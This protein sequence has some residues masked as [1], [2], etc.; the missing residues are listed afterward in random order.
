VPGTTGGLP[1]QRGLS[2]TSNPMAERLR[3]MGRGEDKMLVHMTP[4]EVGGL[5]QLAMAHGGS[6]TINPQTGLP[7]AGFLSKLLPTILGI[8]GAAFGLPTWAIGLGVGAGQTALTG[9]LG[10]GLT[11][12]L[13]AFGGAGIGQAAG[14]GG[15][16]SNNALGLMGGNAASS[17]AAAGSNLFSAPSVS[18]AP[19]AIP[20]AASGASKGFLGKFADATSLGQKGMIGKALP[21]MAGSA[22]LGGVSDAMQ[23]KMPTYN[24]D[25][26]GKSTYEGPYVP[27]KRDVQFQPYEQMKQT[28]GAE[29]KYFT[30]SN[31][32]PG[33]RPVSSLDEE[34]RAEYGFADGGI[35]QL[36]TP[37]GFN[38]LV[39][40]FNSANP[41]AVTA[42]M[43]PSSAAPASP[44]APAVGVPGTS[45][46][47]SP[48]VSPQPNTGGPGTGMIGMPELSSVDIANI[49]AQIGYAPKDGSPATTPIPERDIAYA[50][51]TDLYR[52]ITD[53]P[54]PYI[55]SNPMMPGRDMDGL[56]YTT[57][58][59][60]IQ[61][62]N[63]LYDRL[64][65]N[66][67]TSRDVDYNFAD[68]GAAQVPTPQGF[69]ELTSFFNAVNP[70]AIT[71]SMRPTSAPLPTPAAPAVGAPREQTYNFAN[72][73]S[74]TPMPGA[75]SFKDI[76]YVDIPGVGNVMI[77]GYSNYNF[78]NIDQNE[79]ARRYGFI[80]KAEQLVIREP[81]MTGIYDRFNMVENQLRN[82][83]APQAPDLTGIY[84]RFGQIEDRIRGI[85]QYQ[86]P[87]LSGIYDRFGQIESRISGMP[88]YQEPDLTGIYDRFGSIENQLRNIPTT[89]LTGIY[90][91]FGSI[92]NRLQGIPQYQEP[93]LSGIYDRFGQ[94]EN[95]LQNI[96]PTDLT[97]VYD[98]FG[99][100]ENRISGIPRYQEPD[101]SGVYDRFGQIES[102]LQNITPTDLTGVYDRFG[103]IETRLQNIT[104]TDLTGVYDRFGQIEN[105]LGSMTPTD[106]TGVYD[107]FN[108]L[109]GRFNSLPTPT[110]TDLTGVYDRFNQLEGRFNSLPAPTATD[111]SGIYDRFGQLESRISSLPAPTATDLSGV[112]DRFN[113]LEGRFNNL[114]AP[115]ATDLTGVYDRFNQLEGRISSMPA[116][117]ATD[118]TGV[119][120]RFNQL[121]GRVN[122]IPATD[123]TGVYDR[124]GQIESR[125]GSM[126]PTDL[127]GVYDQLAEL[128]Q[129]YSNQ[130]SS[131]NVT[132]PSISGGSTPTSVDTGGFYARGGEVGMSDGAFVVDARTVSELGNGSSN[133]GMDFLSRLGGRPLRG[134][135]DGV[136]DSIPARIG[137]RQEARVARDEVIFQ[138]DAVKRIGGGSEQRGTAKLYSLMDKAHKARKKA[139]R[140]EDTGLRKALA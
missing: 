92:E 79:I 55:I 89:D 100:I 120:D 129:L 28:G 81:D 48:P 4:G 5:Q 99:Q 35:A 61:P 115:T 39:S 127:T 128:R 139:K 77:P 51:S 57:P 49:L 125:L 135:G 16:I 8:A 72:R 87:D 102:R 43:Y 60:N 19:T 110:A 41:G 14:L 37:Q 42:S 13:Q 1:A 64:E 69:N 86:E 34:E 105:R 121:E 83:P 71:A 54:D 44:A 109:E 40:F 122:S 30:P 65:N 90:D 3:S 132:A 9:D 23:P 75:D 46:R 26:E 124:F 134:P 27:G 93:D 101:L 113:Q 59:L 98:R 123:L 103:S 10:K 56:Y 33:F 104:P 11:A 38:E 24:P 25:E 31:P 119:Y 73:P 78:G 12:G 114:P 63:Q 97:G 80:P 50:P 95:R 53:I 94:I 70:G 130:I 29:A 62:P 58:S 117:T 138:P 108:Q 91:R 67:S 85:P 36:P 82:M 18:G 137:G 20:S 88:Q 68:G 74:V 66:L 2:V 45:N 118:L 84:D 52:G 140:G 76:G 6:L 32:L 107:R 22:V 21:M 106:L 17:T 112:Y 136:S 116:P 126:T 47:P 15:S 111:L 133:A 131:N 7:E 96:T